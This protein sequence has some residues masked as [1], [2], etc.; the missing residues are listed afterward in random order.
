MDYLAQMRQYLPLNEQEAADK[1][2]MVEFAEQNPRTV[3]LRENEIAH[4][5]SSGFIMNP[6]LTKSLMVYHTIRD[7]WAW[8]GGHADGETDLLG[9]ALR[10]AQE[11]TGI[12]AV[13]PLFNSIASLDILFQPGHVKNGGCINAHLH[14]S[15]AYIL[16]CG[17]DEAL[18]VKPD[19][20]K[21][22]RWIPVEE[23]G[24]HLFSKEDLAFYHKLVGKARLQSGLNTQA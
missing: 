23:F 12:Q 20:N 8:T 2:V 15:V 19:E 6:A 5:T 16:V 22:V 1:R 24:T 9:V 14:L 17:E 4:I 21:G 11:E 18:R 7:T 13:T 3:L 10:E